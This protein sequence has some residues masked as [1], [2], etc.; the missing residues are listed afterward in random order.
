MFISLPDWIQYETEGHDVVVEFG[1]GLFKRINLVDCPYRIG[2]EISE[3]YIAE[4]GKLGRLK[5]CAAVCGDIR[6][7]YKL[8]PHC[9]YDCAMIIDV[10][11]HLPA[12]DAK[13]FIASLQRNF[14]K[15]L[16]MIP[17]GRYIQQGD[18]T[19]FGEHEYQTHRSYWK[20]P[21]IV[22]MGFQE[23]ILMPG[24][25]KIAPKTGCI[26]ATWRNDG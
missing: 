4:A 6:E 21:D 17:A 7:Y 14:N 23:I 22:K 5:D 24:Y 12:K 9:T 10:L 16:L 18:P 26:F 25:H 1:A 8:I 20:V 15:I 11:E 19:G 3:K 13:Q 2:I